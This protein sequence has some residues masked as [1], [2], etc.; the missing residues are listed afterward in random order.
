MSWFRAT[1]SNTLI[2]SDVQSVYI[3]SSIRDW[4]LEVKIW[5]TNR[6]Y[7]SRL[8]IP[9]TETIRILIR[10]TWMNRVMHNTCIKHGTNIRIRYIGSTSIWR[11][12]LYCIRKSREKS[13]ERHQRTG[14]LLDAY[15]SSYSRVECWQELVFTRVEIW[16][17]DGS[18]NKESCLWRT[19]Q[20]VH[21]HNT[22]TDLLLKTMIWILTPKQNQKCRQNSDH[23]C[24]GW[25]IKC[26]RGRTNPQKM[27]QK[28][29]TNILWYRECLGLLHCKHLYSWSRIT[30]TICSPSKIQKILHWNR[31]SR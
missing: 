14:R 1:S 29:A 3:P 23:S 27:Q 11:A 7:S 6:Q 10:S 25:M 18:K 5:A 22:R 13:N 24:T 15:S 17:I 20:F 28:T 2:M 26:E 21:P 4:Y 31:C 30:R 8:W 19:T 9:W 16:W 12:C